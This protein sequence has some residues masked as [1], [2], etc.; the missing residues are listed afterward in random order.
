MLIPL[1]IVES[2]KPIGKLFSEELP[3]AAA[4]RE[5]YP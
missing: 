5:L 1:R 4:P 3:L 2:V